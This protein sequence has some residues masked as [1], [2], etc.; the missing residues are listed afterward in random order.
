MAP[1]IYCHSVSILCHMILFL[2]ISTLPNNTYSQDQSPSSPTTIAQCT[3]SLLPLIPCAPFVQGTARSPG[4]E[5]CGNLKQLYSQEP[6]C[7]CLL[8]DGTNLSFF[9]INKTLA[10]Q[11]PPLCNLQVNAN[12]SACLGEEMHMPPAT[13]PHSQVSLGTK[14]NSTVI[15][16]PA[17]SVPPRPNMMGFPGI[18]SSKAI[19]LKTGNRLFVVSIVLIFFC[20]F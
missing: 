10:L 16:S 4:P 13:S 19:T 7:L 12:I 6:H 11:L 15:A 3:S 17:F 8:L 2:L 1:L 18:R 14:N 5:C 9:P 20:S